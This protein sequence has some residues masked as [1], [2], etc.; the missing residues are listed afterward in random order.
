MRAAIVTCLAM[1]L[2][3]WVSTA[4]SSGASPPGDEL[5]EGAGKSI[6]QAKCTTCHTL[7][8]LPKFRSYNRA[9]WR[10]LVVTMRDYGAKVDEREIDVLADY[11]VEHFGTRD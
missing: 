5:P 9:E 10:N 2:V 7:R 1:L 3:T 11:L 4:P 8:E 6:L